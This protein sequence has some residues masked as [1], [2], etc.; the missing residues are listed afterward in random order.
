MLQPPLWGVM[1][2][3]AEPPPVASSSYH[4]M[5]GACHGWPHFIQLITFSLDGS[6]F[7][8]QAYC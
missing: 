4:R 5:H 1:S 8:H 3:L 6:L 7:P 2:V